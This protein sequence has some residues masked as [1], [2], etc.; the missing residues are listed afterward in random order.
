MGVPLWPFLTQSRPSD[1]LHT[2]VSLIGRAATLICRA[3][4]WGIPEILNWFYKNGH[5]TF[6]KLA[7]EQ[8]TKNENWEKLGKCLRQLGSVAME[9]SD[10]SK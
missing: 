6:S 4:G 8:V 5:H 7:G 9:R 3:K 2:K 1:L 10:R